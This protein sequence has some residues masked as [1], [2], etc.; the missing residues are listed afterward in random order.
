MS[1]RKIVEIV[2]EL[3][4]SFVYAHQSEFGGGSSIALSISI[5]R[6]ASQ[7]ASPFRKAAGI[8]TVSWVVP[9]E[10]V[11]SFETR[12]DPWKSINVE[13]EAGGAMGSNVMVI[14]LLR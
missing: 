5:T 7:S 6:P 3:F 10:R 12:N 11:M 8:S 9:D 2:P 1:R 14:V 13:V 4:R